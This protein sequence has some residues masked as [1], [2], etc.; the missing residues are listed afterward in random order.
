[1]R[2]Y[3]RVTRDDTETCARGIE[4]DTVETLRIELGYLTTIEIGDDA[5]VDTHAMKV[6]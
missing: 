4:Q 3:T 1:L 5:V 6:G 2:P